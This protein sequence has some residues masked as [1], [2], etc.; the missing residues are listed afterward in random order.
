MKKPLRLIKT[1]PQIRRNAITT[2]KN[3]AY[4]PAI[5]QLKEKGFIPIKVEHRTN[6]YLNNIVEQDHRRIKRPLK[7]KGPF[8]PFQSAKNI[9]IG[10]ESHALFRKKQV[11][12][13][14]LFEIVYGDNYA[15]LK[16]A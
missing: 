1:T 16:S 5:S 8:K 7:G 6:K 4:P 13:S 15:L 10:I 3:A 2:D 12:K 14:V 9:L 11:D